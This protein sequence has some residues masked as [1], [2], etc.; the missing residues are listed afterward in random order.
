M[1]TTLLGSS[2]NVWGQDPTVVTPDYPN[3]GLGGHLFEKVNIQLSGSWNTDDIANLAKALHPYGVL[4]SENPNLQSVTCASD[5]EF[6]GASL[7]LSKLFKNCTSLISV[8]LPV[9]SSG[10]VDFE[11]AFYGCTSLKR[12]NSNEDVINLTTFSA[13]I[14][15]LKNAFYSCTEAVSITLPGYSTGAVDLGSA[16]YDCTSLQCINSNEDGIFNL[17]AFSAGIS[18]LNNTFNACAEAVSITL[19]NNLSADTFDFSNAFYNCT[20]LKRI[21]SNTDGVFDL[22]S[23]LSPDVNVSISGCFYNCT[24]AIDIRM[25]GNSASATSLAGTFK[26]CASLKRVNSETDGLFDLTAFS[27]GL[28]ASLYYTFENCQYAES[29]KLPDTNTTSQFNLRYAFSGCTSLK[30]INSETDGVFDI[31]FA[32]AKIYAG[33]NGG[34][35]EAFKN[36]T[37]AVT[38]ILPA[39]NP[40]NMSGIRFSSAFYG[41]TSLQTIEKLDTYKVFYSVD[42]TFKGCSSLQFVKIGALINNVITTE[43]RAS[44]TFDDT[45]PNCLKYL[46]AEETEIHE[47][48]SGYSNFIIDTNANDDITLNLSYPYY[49]PIAIT[50]DDKII[51]GSNT[52]DVVKKNGST[53]TS[54]W[55]TICMP[56]DADVYAGEIKLTPYSATNTNGT[57][58][59]RQFTSSTTNMVNFTDVS[60]TEGE[61]VIKANTTYI[62]AFPGSGWGNELDLAEGGDK[63]S[64]T[65]KSATNYTVP[66]TPANI[67]ET[68]TDSYYIFSGGYMTIGKDKAKEYYVLNKEQNKFIK[69]DNN[70]VSPFTAY[71]KLA[72]GNQPAGAPIVLSIGG[73]D[74][75]GGLT[76]IENPVPPTPKLKVYTE[77]GDIIIVSPYAQRVILYTISG[78]AIRQIDLT[79]GTNRIS[80]LPHGVYLFEYIKI[81]L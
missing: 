44:G 54:S 43:G 8:D 46:P 77:E 68:P 70:N 11:S 14:S 3:L 55:Y 56:F 80:G 69:D 62:I 25:P 67:S 58:W 13:G 75:G 71:F 47:D 65:Y 79:E 63:V 32:E 1:I 5:V 52:Y 15:N 61:A 53:I 45:N 39:Y 41:C 76:N 72:A 59:L 18:N 17:T 27:E 10:P 38:I 30:R 23:F 64:I 66:I 2:M 22:A 6:T 21:N 26:G 35:T 19:P 49:C 81:V 48:W 51:K 50:M 20:S 33:N 28:T 9:F 40:S 60:Y 24:E 42:N 29:I 73:G 12:I 34:F 57:F 78:Q 4:D 74:D 7:S 36:C 37:H 31:S 16:F